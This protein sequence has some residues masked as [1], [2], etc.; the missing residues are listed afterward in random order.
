MCVGFRRGKV[1][2]SMI[3]HRRSCKYPQSSPSLMSWVLDVMFVIVA[4][5]GKTKDQ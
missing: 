2:T 4:V 5:C 1:G 3:R